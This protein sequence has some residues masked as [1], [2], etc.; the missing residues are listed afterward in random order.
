ME[1]QKEEKKTQMD[2]FQILTHTHTPLD[3]ELQSHLTRCI[4][5]THKEREWKSVQESG[6]PVN[7]SVSEDH[8]NE[9]KITLHSRK[10][11]VEHF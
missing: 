1:T 4:H 6:K 2:I 9:P 10:H 5:T 8:T 11:P 3:L 7:S